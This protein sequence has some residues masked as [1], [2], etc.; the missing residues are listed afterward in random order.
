MRSAPLWSRWASQCP[1]RVASFDELTALFEQENGDPVTNGRDAAVA[2]WEEK[3]DGGGDETSSACRTWRAALPSCM[4]STSMLETA[5]N[6]SATDI[7]IEPARE[8]V[9]VRLR[10]DGVLRLHQ[11]LPPRMARA[12]VSRVKILAGLNIAERRLPQDGRAR[13]MIG[14]NEADLRIATM[15]TLH[16][17]AVVIRILVKEASA[18]DLSRLGMAPADLKAFSEE[19]TEPHGLIVVSGP[20]GSGKTTT[21]AAALSTLNRPEPRS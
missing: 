11:S 3:N 6:M 5:I 8:G 17:E 20:T 12:V 1:L 14:R 4:R 9:R 10:V 16:G 15:P 21:L 19:L 2:G 13:V 18:L 7:H